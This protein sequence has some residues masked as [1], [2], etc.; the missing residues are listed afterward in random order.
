[1]ISQSIECATEV[2]RNNVINLSVA[3]VNSNLL[4]IRSLKKKVVETLQVNSLSKV[5]KCPEN[6]MNEHSPNPGS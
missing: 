4:C 3:I 5:H 6:G 2:Q 1:M